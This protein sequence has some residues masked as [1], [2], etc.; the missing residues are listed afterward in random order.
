MARMIRRQGRAAEQAIPGEE[1][2]QQ[3]LRE[4]GKV[5]RGTPW[6]RH[7]PLRHRSGKMTLWVS[8]YRGR[9]LGRRRGLFHGIDFR[10]RLHDY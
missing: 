7:G 5:P 4:G 10:F 8:G 1:H 9:W 6:G 3:P 2:A